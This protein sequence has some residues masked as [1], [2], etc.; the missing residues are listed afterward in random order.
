V[1]DVPRFNEFGKKTNEQMY[2][3]A[4][5]MI[6]QQWAIDR[7]MVKKVNYELKEVMM[8]LVLESRQAR[9]QIRIP[10]YFHHPVVPREMPLLSP[11]PSILM[12]YREYDYW[13][14]NRICYFPKQFFVDNI[15][16]T[17]RWSTFAGVS[18]SDTAVKSLTILAMRAQSAFN[19]AFAGN[20]S[21]D[22]V[23]RSL[24]GL[25]TGK[26]AMS[27][28]KFDRPTRDLNEYGKSIAH[29]LPLA[30]QR[31]YQFMGV[32]DKFQSERFDPSFVRYDTPTASS[33][34][35]RSG[36]KHS[37][38][39]GE[40]KVKISPMGRKLEQREYAYQEYKRMV[41]EAKEGMVPRLHD[42]AWIVSPK[43]E[44][45]TRIGKTPAE[46]A[47]ALEKLRHYNIGFYSGYLLEVHVFK[48][49]Q[50]YERG[51]MIRIGMKWWYGGAQQLYDDLQGGDDDMEYSDGDVKNYDMS[52]KR[53][54]MEFYVSSAALYYKR[55]GEYS[56][57]MRM[58]ETAMMYLTRRITHMY[59]DSW[60]VIIGGMPSGAYVTSHGDSWILALMFWWF[61]EHL[62]N[63]SPAMR[64]LINK[65]FS[66]GKILIVVYGDDHIIGAHKSISH[67]INET[68]FA[69]WLR[70]FL[71]MEVR[72]V[73]HN[74]PLLSEPTGNGGLKV[75]GVVFLKRYLIRR[76]SEMPSD[77][78]NVL[79]YRPTWQYYHKIPF[80]SGSR[81][82]MA[83]LVLSSLG[84]AYDTMGTNTH[85]YQFLRFVYSYCMSTP[86]MVGKNIEEI[87]RESFELNDR[88]DMTR[89]MR[90]MGITAD[91]LKSG[92]PSLTDLWNKNRSDP[93]RRAYQQ[94]RM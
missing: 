15:W 34:G 20:Q 29:L 23:F 3:I 56:T 13:Y 86:S 78:P 9:N 90:K 36:V 71:D 93:G 31:M 7:H 79:C 43:S 17:S 92:F 25:H 49:R 51:K 84:N 75:K 26:L 41:Q 28:A 47:I 12:C 58:L 5:A 54:L 11:E 45:F 55:D 61:V 22:Y 6:A 64:I 83:D 69:R 67:L 24:E 77:L 66:R 32:D 60:R 38:M 48:V 30:L 73:T 42:E 82:T 14:M 59:G 62:C 72:D 46:M 8:F 4:L 53:V 52:V 40:L 76:T 88:N 50:L 80:G 63:E 19:S 65:W 70:K 74:I 35:A 87:Y 39:I 33:S 57:Y 27:L 81:R 68:Q 94:H 16:L 21:G 2:Y 18:R 1:V 91:E 37:F 44:V 85:A 10:A 89:V